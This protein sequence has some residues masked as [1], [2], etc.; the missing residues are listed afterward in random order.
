MHGTVRFYFSF[1]SPYAWFAAERW[2]KEMGVTGIS[3]E[4]IPFFPT[5]ALFPNDPTLFPNKYRYVI[6]DVGR[7]AHAYGLTLV[8]PHALDTDWARAH[9]A[10]LAV[11]AARPDRAEAF[12]LEMYRARFSLG[13]DVAEDAAI[14]SAAERSGVDPAIPLAGAVSAALQARVAENLRV[15]QER[16]GIFGAP[17]FVYRDELFW[18]HDRMLHLRATILRDRATVERDSGVRLAERDASPVQFGVG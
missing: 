13:V 1:R 10:Y 7:L 6:R 2:Q 9:A 14:S 15:G 4:R 11:E 18:G 8:P 3:V 12:M 17:S 5:P 16:D